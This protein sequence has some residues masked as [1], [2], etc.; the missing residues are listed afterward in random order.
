MI[1]ILNIKGSGVEKYYNDAMIIRSE[2][3]NK[4]GKLIGYHELTKIQ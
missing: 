2:S 3:Y 4:K 1:G